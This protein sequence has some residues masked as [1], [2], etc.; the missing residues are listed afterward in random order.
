MTE[1]QRVTPEEFV[2]IK[3]AIRKALP[4]VRFRIMMRKGFYVWVAL[5][6]GPEPARNGPVRFR[7]EED[8][9]QNPQL[10]PMLRAIDAAAATVK[11][12]RR[13]DGN[14]TVRDYAVEFSVGTFNTK[15]RH[16]PVPASSSSDA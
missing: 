2:R 9:S 5:M 3:K 8:L 16:M 6:S 13:V 12:P 10:E 4:G 11:P 1:E 15:Y 14:L 7:E